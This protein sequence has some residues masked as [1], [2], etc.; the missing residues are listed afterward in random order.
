MRDG[1]SRR[2]GLS[3]LSSS[4]LR[5]HDWRLGSCD[6]GLE[7][8]GTFPACPPSVLRGRSPTVLSPFGSSASSVATLVYEPFSGYSGDEAFEGCWLSVVFVSA[9]V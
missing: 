8:S 1:V 3:L 5:S 7:H 6:S 9:I 2:R 4:A